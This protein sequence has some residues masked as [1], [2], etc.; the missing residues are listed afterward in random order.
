MAT[1]PRSLRLSPLVDDAD[2]MGAATDRAMDGASHRILQA[3][4]S[5]DLQRKPSGGFKMKLTNLLFKRTDKQPERYTPNTPSP[6]KVSWTPRSR[7]AA[8]W[9]LSFFS[10]NKDLSLHGMSSAPT[11]S[12]RSPCKS[13]FD[14]DIEYFQ[15]DES[16]HGQPLTPSHDGCMKHHVSDCPH[17]EEVMLPIATHREAMLVLRKRFLSRV[18][19][20][21]LRAATSAPQPIPSKYRPQEAAPTTPGLPWSARNTPPQREALWHTPPQ[22]D[23]LWQT[24]PR[25]DALWTGDG[26]YASTSCPTPSPAKPPI[27]RR[28]GGR[29]PAL[30]TPSAPI[31]RTWVGGPASN[32]PGSAVQQWLAQSP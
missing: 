2:G 19:V 6:T 28:G 8:A 29:P 31:R 3:E 25:R 27:L 22:R 16:E 1:G 24:P 23:A 30:S 4:A 12:A 11:E 7:V 10:K 5:E 26:F 18:V 15:G 9:G 32:S 14:E 20:V 21:Q 17:C 13:Q